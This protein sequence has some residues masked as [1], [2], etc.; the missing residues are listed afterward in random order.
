MPFPECNERPDVLREMGRR[1]MAFP[2]HDM[3]QIPVVFLGHA[4]SAKK[5]IDEQLGPLQQA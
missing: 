4:E 2:F 5:R 3:E 1:L